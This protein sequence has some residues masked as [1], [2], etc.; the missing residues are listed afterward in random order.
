MPSSFA[1][2]CSFSRLTSL[3]HNLGRSSHSCLFLLYTAH[4]SLRWPIRGERGWFVKSIEQPLEA[5]LRIRVTVSKPRRVF[6]DGKELI[7]PNA[8]TDIQSVGE[9]EEKVVVGWSFYHWHFGSERG[10]R[11]PKRSREKPR[12]LSGRSLSISIS[13]SAEGGQVGLIG[14][15][16]GWLGRNT[17]RARDQHCQFSREAKAL[18]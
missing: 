17:E 4:S 1:S 13:L 16:V 6:E 2:F 3:S 10:L 14:W 8:T 9:K 7:L 18:I 12:T 5:G 11:P 15:L